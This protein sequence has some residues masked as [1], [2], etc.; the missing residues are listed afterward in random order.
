MPVHPDV[1]PAAPC[2]ASKWPGPPQRSPSAEVVVGA[3]LGPAALPRRR[4]RGPEPPRRLAA[5]DSDYDRG[6][7]PTGGSTEPGRV[8]AGAQRSR[9]LPLQP[10]LVPARSEG[11]IRRA[12]QTCRHRGLAQAE[13]I[14]EGLLRP[15]CGIDPVRVRPCRRPSPNS[16]RLLRDRSVTGAGIGGC[17]SAPNSPLSRHAI[18]VLL[19]VKSAC[20]NR[21][22]CLQQRFR[23][24]CRPP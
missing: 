19:G 7:S 22:L 9:A 4:S 18:P 11:R 14:A 2:R 8:V 12:T 16:F 5:G 1:H 20:L 17:N 21:R 10:S 3:R 23:R 6:A 24:A 15:P 13:S